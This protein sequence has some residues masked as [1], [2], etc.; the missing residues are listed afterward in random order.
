MSVVTIV[1]AAFAY[2]QNEIDKKEGIVLLIL[3]IAYMTFA[4]CRL[5]GMIQV[6]F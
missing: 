6:S 5:M 1:V 3:Y 2:T 4:C